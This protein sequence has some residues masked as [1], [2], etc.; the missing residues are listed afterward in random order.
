MKSEWQ[1]LLGEMDM[2]PGILHSISFVV[3]DMIVIFESCI[4][5]ESRIQLSLLNLS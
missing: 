2:I 3:Q 1:E 5:H 4:N